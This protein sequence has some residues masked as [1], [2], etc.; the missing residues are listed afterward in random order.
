MTSGGGSGKGVRWRGLGVGASVVLHL[1][2]LLP[3]GLASPQLKRRP[4]AEPVVVI[5][6]SL[7]PVERRSKPAALRS[8][9]PHRADR[10]PGSPAELA[11]QPE[12]TDRA[13]EASPGAG[14]PDEIPGIEAQWR[15]RPAEGW[16]A[17]AGR[18]LGP[19]CPPPESDP[20]PG[21]CPD[22]RRA[23]AQSEAYAEIA[24]SRAA[25]ADRARQEAFDR[26]AS[27]N[28]AWRNYTRGEGAY[29][30]LRSLFTQR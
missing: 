6:V 9:E 18:R 22:G 11:P 14:R 3:I 8:P 29:P 5:P 4:A 27:A 19:P 23:R 7:V 1:V 12:R 21:S 2:L 26:Q 20:A 17:R 16:A 10:P 28:E 24:P 30:G 25:D 13:P 15:V